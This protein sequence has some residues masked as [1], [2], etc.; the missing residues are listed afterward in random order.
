MFVGFA[1]F[2]VFLGLVFYRLVG[3]LIL[4]L[5]TWIGEL[6]G[7]LILG[8]LGLSDFCGFEFC[9]LICCL[10]GLLEVGYCSFD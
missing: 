10:I 7:L 1:N 3:L 2:V 5:L 9:Y 4:L 8:F 6:G